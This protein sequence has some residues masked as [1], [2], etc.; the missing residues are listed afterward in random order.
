MTQ[1]IPLAGVIGT[2]IAHS[3]SPRLHQHWLNKYG[4]QGHYIPM[5]VASDDL[6]EALKFLPRLGFVGLN[7]WMFS[8]GRSSISSA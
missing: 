5:D 6:E 1:K 7:V 8:V 4:I 3:K 2:P